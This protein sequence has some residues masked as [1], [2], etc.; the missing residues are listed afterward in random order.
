M[1]RTSSGEW[2]RAQSKGTLRNGRLKV[3]GFHRTARRLRRFEVEDEEEPDQ[4]EES[5]ECISPS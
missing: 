3:G 4:E 2:R 5:D 1:A